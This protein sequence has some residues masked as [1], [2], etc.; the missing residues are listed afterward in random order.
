[1][2]LCGLKND[3]DIVEFVGKDPSFCTTVHDIFEPSF[4]SEKPFNTSMVLQDILK[5][6]I[7]DFSRMD[8]FNSKKKRFFEF[9]DTDADINKSINCSVRYMDSSDLK[10]FSE[11]N[12]EISKANTKKRIF[13]QKLFL[14][15]VE[16]KYDNLFKKNV[17]RQ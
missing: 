2:A 17:T 8:D 15:V 5:A 10:I 13:L 12:L 11:L 4:E 6:N 3:S 9:K 1:M 7:C 14:P 16:V